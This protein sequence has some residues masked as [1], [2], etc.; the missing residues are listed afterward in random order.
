MKEDSI[1]QRRINDKIRARNFRGRVHRP[2]SNQRQV[3]TLFYYVFKSSPGGFTKCAQSS[4]NFHL[5]AFKIVCILA[6]LLENDFASLV[7][8]RAII[9]RDITP[10]TDNFRAV[11]A[12]ITRVSPFFPSPIDF[13]PLL[14][15][16]PSYFCQLFVISLEYLY[17]YKNI[18][19]FVSTGWNGRGEDSPRFKIFTY[20][21]LTIL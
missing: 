3:L 14:P 18:R 11:S 16:P 9:C 5:K 10:D 8:G 12:R 6:R 20:I 2:K 19:R 21:F 7:T 4:L 13:S 15:P 17:L 1:F